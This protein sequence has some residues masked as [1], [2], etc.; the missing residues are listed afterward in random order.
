M[1]IFNPLKT[2]KKWR[3]SSAAINTNPVIKPFHSSKKP[4]AVYDESLADGKTGEVGIR[5][6]E[7]KIQKKIRELE[8]SEKLRYY[9]VDEYKVSTNKFRKTIFF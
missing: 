2:D 8:E 5:K 9:T 6:N 1:E 7:T 3:H 4:F